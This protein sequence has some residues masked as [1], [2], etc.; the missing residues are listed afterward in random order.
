MLTL[1]ITV[2][3]MI[4]S[5]CGAAGHKPVAAPLTAKATRRS[6][7]IYSVLLNGSDAHPLDIAGI[8]LSR[9]PDGRIAFLRGPRL[10]VM[11]DDGRNVRVLARAD[12]GSEDPRTPAWSP[13]GRYIAAGNGSGCDPFSDCVSSNV[14]VIDVASGRE[15]TVIPWGK[16]PSWSP[17]G[18][19]IAY[20]GG[21]VN[22][23]RHTKVPLGIFVAR[24]NGRGRRLLASGG[25]PAWSPNGTL[26]AFFAI[27]PSGRHLGLHLSRPDG[28]AE[29]AL[30]RTE[31]EF[32][33]APDGRQL[34]YIGPFGFPNRLS[35][36]SVRSGQTRRIG[37]ADFTQPGAI[38]WSPDG[39]RLVWVAFDYRRNED[40]LLIASSN[41]SDQPRELVHSLRRQRIITPVFSGDGKRV[42][43]SLW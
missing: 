38:A 24:P 13:D 4:P 2:L 19:V 8:G 21:S 39:S 35:V 9:G 1:L 42:L 22:G 18:N 25:L 23:D 33:W 31:P 5:G 11:N 29:R 41:G 14:S 37:P 6:P 30:A 43:Y 27:S 28:T 32:A 17:R 16:E 20:E 12:R 40:R 34:A 15:R 3:S 26:I 10:V 7:Q 36:V